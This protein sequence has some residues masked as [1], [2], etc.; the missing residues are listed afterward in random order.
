[1]D[2]TNRTAR[3]LVLRTPNTSHQ[4]WRS[5]FVLICC[6]AYQVTHTH[7]CALIP[8]LGFV[9]FHHVAKPLLYLH[10]YWANL[11]RPRSGV[12]S[13]RKTS[14]GSLVRI[15]ISSRPCKSPQ[16]DL[17]NSTGGDRVPHRVQGRWVLWRAEGSQVHAWLRKHRAIWSHRSHHALCWF[18][19]WTLWGLWPCLPH[20]CISRDQ[21]DSQ[22][23]LGTQQC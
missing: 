5:P 19:F 4:E 3:R 10:I 13:S 22:H 7:I 17:V 14:L 11:W 21:R 16:L 20:F 8:P 12:T 23:K 2:H 18:H 15:K 6:C 1:M 9:F